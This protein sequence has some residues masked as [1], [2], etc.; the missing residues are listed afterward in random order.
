LPQ[1]GSQMYFLKHLPSHFIIMYL[2]TN[3]NSVK[4]PRVFVSL[5]AIPQ[6]HDIVK[7]IG[8]RNGVFWGER[9]NRLCPPW[10]MV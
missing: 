6:N 2:I 10:A 8:F 7:F 9:S 3:R 1:V 5:L 4:L